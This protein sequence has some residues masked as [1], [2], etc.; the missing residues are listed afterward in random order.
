MKSLLALLAAT[1]LFPMAVRAQQTESPEAAAQNPTQASP[2]AAPAAPAA[3][4]AVS[5][6][7]AASV[8]PLP[9]EAVPSAP[10]LEKPLPLMPENIP[11]GA[12]PSGHHHGGNA[13]GGATPPKDTFG[14]ESDIRGR[15]HFR[16]AEIQ[17]QN[18]PR[19]Q[20]D[21]F[22]A[23]QTRNDPDRREALTKYY[24]DLTA[25]IVKIDPTVAHQADVRR[26]AAIDRLHYAHLGD[27]PPDQ[28]PF[29]AA[30]PAA[31]ESLNPPAQDTETG[32]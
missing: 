27:E 22:A 4:P 30:P 3:S 31:V 21:W 32:Y 15:I 8:V 9:G 10:S 18:E 16:V 29:A 7:E 24:N 26:I 25:E 19:I 13:G 23:H 14:V 17:A 1:A 2:A 20:A 28:D 6:S 11:P 12:Q 5:G